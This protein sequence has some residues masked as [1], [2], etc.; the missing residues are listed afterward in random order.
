MSLFT[1]GFNYFKDYEMPI[2]TF[3]KPQ[4]FISHLLT[5]DKE[6]VNAYKMIFLT[7]ANY[8][9]SINEIPFFLSGP[10]VL[11]LNNEDHFQ[12]HSSSEENVHILIFHPAILNTIFDLYSCDHPNDY[13]VSQLQ[14][15][16]YFSLFQHSRTTQEKVLKLSNIGLLNALQKLDTIKQNT[17]LQTTSFWPCQ[18]RGAL[19]ELLFLQTIPTSFLA[20]ASPEV[21]N[22]SPLVV[23][24]IQFLEE[25]YA[26]KISLDDISQAFNTNRT[27]LISEFKKVTTLSPYRYLLQIRMNMATTLLRKTEL[28]IDEICYRTGFNDLGYF[29]KLFKKELGYSP[30]EY[31]KLN[32]PIYC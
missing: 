31:R 12:F 16:F 20:P 11:C 30:G 26:E 24:A 32:E 23:E 6:A 15:L 18:T 17:T 1:R 5:E 27:T 21:Y 19:L 3:Y 10:H 8:E 29:S 9:F 22:E 2:T 25:H 13:S 4:D 28:P 7:Q 14:D